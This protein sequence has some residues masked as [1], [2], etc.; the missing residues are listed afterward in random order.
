MSRRNEKL[1]AKLM[2][3][4]EA[5][6]DEL[7]ANRKDPRE[8]TLA[9]IEQAVLVAGQ[10]I[11]QELTEALVTESALE[12]EGGWPRCAECGG[13]MKAKGKRVK[14]LVTERGEVRLEREYYY[15]AACRSGIFPPG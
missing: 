8:A 3:K 15:C 11:E 14:R 9:D 6:I 10:Q 7:L 12:V 2:V 1:K 5:V 4:A 13:R